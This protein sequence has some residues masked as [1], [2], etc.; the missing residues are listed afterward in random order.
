MLDS[1]VLSLF[2]E[3]EAQATRTERSKC[4]HTYLTLWTFVFGGAKSA[5]ASFGLCL[6]C[7]KLTFASERF[8]TTPCG[9]APMKTPS[10]HALWECDL[11]LNDR[12][13]LS[14]KCHGTDEPFAFQPVRKCLCI[15]GLVPL[16]HLTHWFSDQLDAV[17]LKQC[18]GTL[19][20]Q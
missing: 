15:C 19:E 1:R 9:V 6:S 7:R 3:W 18:S 2:A 5:E 8:Y 10:L 14:R 11:N 17:L 13:A 4:K 16:E 20:H 12:I